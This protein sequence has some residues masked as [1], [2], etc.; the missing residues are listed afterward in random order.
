MQVLD[1]RSRAEMKR[2]MD[3]FRQIL[4]KIEENPEMDGTREFYPNSPE[5][6]GIFDHSTEEVAY[7]IKL[8]IEA[9]LVDGAVTVYMPMQIIRN[10]TNEGHDFLDDIRDDTIW[11]KVKERVAGLPSVGISVIAQIALAEVKAK[12]HLS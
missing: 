10:L 3:L 1:L 8:L 6:I 11:Q 5:E 9:G 12:L 2:D 7:H 4:F